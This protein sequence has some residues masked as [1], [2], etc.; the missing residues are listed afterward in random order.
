MVRYWTET[1]Q[2]KT[3]VVVQ[4]ILELDDLLARG[5]VR[6]WE[7]EAVRA[8]ILRLRDGVRC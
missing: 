6:A 8:E 3:A 1:D 5:L 2:A 4:R 7:V